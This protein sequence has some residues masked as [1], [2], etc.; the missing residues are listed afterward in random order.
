LILIVL[1]MVDGEPAPDRALAGEGDADG[2]AS[3]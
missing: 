3:V 2:V 1:S